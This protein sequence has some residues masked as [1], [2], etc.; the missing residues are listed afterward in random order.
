MAMT[1]NYVDTVR[2]NAIVGETIRWSDYPEAYCSDK[3]A[4]RTHEA[5]VVKKCPNI[6]VTDKGSVQWSLIAL[7]LWRIENGHG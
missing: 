2:E 7:Y 5:T 1:I 4:L 3:S 6:C